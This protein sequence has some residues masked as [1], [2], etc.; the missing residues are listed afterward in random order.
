MGKFYAS[1]LFLERF[2]PLI[3][4]GRVVFLPRNAPKTR[5]FMLDEELDTSDVFAAIEKLKPEDHFAGPE[6]D[7]DGT[8]G[9]V[10]VFKHPYKDTNLY[11][12]L[13]L[14]TDARG[15]AGLVMSFHEEGKYE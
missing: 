3:K 6:D 2:I 14:W 8:P 7:H 15:D 12:K 10:M 5:Q 9:K 4:A 1:Q 13:K 11:I